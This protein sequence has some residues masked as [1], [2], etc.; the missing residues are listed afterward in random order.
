MLA[1]A[2]NGPVDGG[3]HRHNKRIKMSNVIAP[4][5]PD[6]SLIARPF[7]NEDVVKI[8]RSP[9]TMASQPVGLHSNS[10]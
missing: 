9:G 1:L 10:I 3:D 8:D 4:C 2:T 5:G 6:R 7:H